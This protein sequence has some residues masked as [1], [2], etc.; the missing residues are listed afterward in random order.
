MHISKLPPE[1]MY[2]IVDLYED[3]ILNDY[4]TATKDDLTK[5]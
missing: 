3:D 5:V 4:E 1:V 2:F